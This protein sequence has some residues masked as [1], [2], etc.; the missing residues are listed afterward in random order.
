MRKIVSYTILN[1]E[2]DIIESFVRYNFVYI[3][4]MIIIDNGCTDHTIDI[5]K[6]LIKEGYDIEI[7]DESLVDFEQFGIM[8]KYLQKIAN[9]YD[10]DIVIPLD[11]DE[12]LMCDSKRVR[13][14]LE[15]MSLD[16]VY[17][18]QWQ[19]FVLRKEDDEKEMFICRKIK[20]SY[21]HRD[22]KVIIPTRL[23]TKDMILRTGQHDILAE[24]IE[25][26][27]LPELKLAHFSYRSIEQAKT[28][29]MCHS[30]K[31]INYLNRQDAEG[32]HRN[33]FASHCIQSNDE[34]WFFDT[35]NERIKRGALSEV[36]YAPMPLE[37]ERMQNVNLKYTHLVTNNAFSNICRLAQVLAVKS[38]NHS[39]E[40]KFVKNVPV[41]MIYGTGNSAK[42]LLTGMPMDIINIRGY[43]NSNPDVEFTMFN[44]RLVVTPKMLKFFRYDRIVI[45]SKEHF[46]EM[47][48]TLISYG[49]LEEK[50]VGI[51]YLMKLMIEKL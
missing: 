48:D 5:L 1:N 19:N 24:K 23:I 25:R 14:V 45:S 27:L 17:L 37:I 40:E 15:K 7:F 43:I 21:L 6:L 8:N 30:I 42:N 11:S 44:R 13:D 3:D 33:V 29:T 32:M 50:I 18:V 47:Y 39:I 51:D 26:V 35:F 31:Y 41:V 28:K 46:R 49:I 20:Y 36:K 4:K 16:K 34:S 38:Y 12:F 2:E 22:Y 9:E 10:S